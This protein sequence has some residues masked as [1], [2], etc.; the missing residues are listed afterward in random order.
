MRVEKDG[1]EID[2]DPARLD[3]E[4]VVRIEMPTAVA[5]QVLAEHE[6]VEVDYAV[7]LWVR[8]F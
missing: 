4:A 3:L 5:E 2:D 7:N 8:R 1:F 6:G